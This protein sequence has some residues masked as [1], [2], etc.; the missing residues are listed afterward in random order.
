[1]RILSEG[2]SARATTGLD[3]RTGLT[4]AI[5]GAVATATSQP[6]ASAWDASR[7]TACIFDGFH[8]RDQVPEPDAGCK[9]LADEM[10][11]VEQDDAVRVARGSGAVASHDDCSGDW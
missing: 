9:S 1:M 10:R 3:D 4:A 11:A 6:E 8:R 7:T 5:T 2:R